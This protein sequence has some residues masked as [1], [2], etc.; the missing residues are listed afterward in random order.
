LILFFIINKMPLTNVLYVDDE[1]QWRRLA[2]A[3]FRKKLAS[4]VDVAADYASGVKKI[5]KRFYDLIVI[6]GLG[7]LCFRLMEEVK[8][9]PH[10]PI[11]IFSANIGI[12]SQAK[13]DGIPFYYKPQDLDK[14]VRTY[15]K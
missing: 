10:G 7:G 2:Q 5:K 9:V 8:E 4:N 3:H 11:A 6:D 12:A 1:A 14:I 15:R 13:K